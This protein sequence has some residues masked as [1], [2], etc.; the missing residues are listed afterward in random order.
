MSKLSKKFIIRSLEAEIE[1]LVAEVAKLR[2]DRENALQEN[3]RLRGRLLDTERGRLLDQDERDAY[4][5]RIDRLTSDLVYLKTK[6]GL[7][8]NTDL[9]DWSARL[10]NYADQPADDAVCAGCGRSLFVMGRAENNSILCYRCGQDR[11]DRGEI[12][13]HEPF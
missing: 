9:V 5:A 10:G 1:R 6:L 4:D 3:A 12:L 8:P 2:D 13:S 7:E 11:Q